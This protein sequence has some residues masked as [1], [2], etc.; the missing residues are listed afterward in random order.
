MVSNGKTI[1]YKSVVRVWEL[2]GDEKPR[3]YDAEHLIWIGWSAQG[4][5]LAVCLEKDGVWLR[6]LRSGRSRHFECPNLGRPDLFRPEDKLCACAPARLL[7]VP[8]VQNVIHVWDTAT[9]K[10]RFT[11][12][13]EKDRYLHGLAISSDGRHLAVLKRARASSYP[14]A[15]IGRAHV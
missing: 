5:P 8:D 9:G 15:E 4:E 10:E 12:E 13:R 6:E 11:L 3:V 1:R 7:A 2:A 14:Y